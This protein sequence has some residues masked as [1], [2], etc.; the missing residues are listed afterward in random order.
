MF[1]ARDKR[2]FMADSGLED[3]SDDGTSNASFWPNRGYR[4]QRLCGTPFYSVSHTV[5]CDDRPSRQLLIAVC[6]SFCEDWQS[7]R[8][9][10]V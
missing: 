1:P 2:I 9:Q 6:G 5:A 4:K 8:S 10:I 7:S 3:S